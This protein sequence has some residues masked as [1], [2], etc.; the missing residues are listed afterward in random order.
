MIETQDSHHCK[1]H[2]Y[3]SDRK[4]SQS[5]EEGRFY[6]FGFFPPLVEP[7]LGRTKGK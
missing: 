1:A 3:A 2:C 5:F 7:G 4:H 6:V